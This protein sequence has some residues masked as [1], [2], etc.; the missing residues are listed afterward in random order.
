M[1]RY[2]FALLIAAGLLAQAQASWAQVGTPSDR[3]V[4]TAP[5][6]A[7]LFD[8]TIPEE[9]GTEVQAIYSPAVPP[10]IVPAGQAVTSPLFGTI[11]L[12]EPIGTVPDPGETSLII[13][14]PGAAP[15]I[16][17][18]ALIWTKPANTA[19]PPYIQLISDG[20]PELRDVANS[21]P[22][23]PA[24]ILLD[25][26]GKLQDLTPLVDSVLVPQGGTIQV[27][28][29]LEVPEPGSI[30]LLALGGIALLARRRR[31]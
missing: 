30:S 7:P 23:I 8:Q 16:L 11:L 9:T 10:V 3:L 1:R 14:I 26:T 13:N 20:D 12:L 19:I 24:P 4:I 18:D 29:D 2:L 6:G 31:A 15:R 22:N 25:E 27:Y 21:F 17:S 28:S 5:T